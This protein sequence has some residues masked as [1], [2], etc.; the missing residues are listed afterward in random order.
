MKQLK[1]ELCQYILKIKENKTQVLANKKMYTKHKKWY[2]VWNLI[3]D[4]V[5]NTLILTGSNN[6]KQTKYL[7]NF[8][9]KTCMN[10]KQNILYYVLVMR[11]IL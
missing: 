6:I 3:P 11:N 5:L 9:V 8:G 7:Y 1:T 4:P 2:D 10:F